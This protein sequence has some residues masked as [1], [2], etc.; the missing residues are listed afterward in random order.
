MTHARTAM[1]VPYPALRRL[2]PGT[3]L[4]AIDGTG[5]HSNHPAATRGS[6]RPATPLPLRP[7]CR[8][9]L[10]HPPG[11]RFGTPLVAGVLQRQDDRQRALY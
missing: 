7:L 1:A 5:E 10:V 11:T 8:S 3:Q 9:Y 6:C 4:R 2:C